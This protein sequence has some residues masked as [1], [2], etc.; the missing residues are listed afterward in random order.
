MKIQE[1]LTK[2]HNVVVTRGDVIRWVETLSNNRPAVALIGIPVV[3]IALEYAR[4]QY[5][6]VH[7]RLAHRNALA[8]LG[9]ARTTPS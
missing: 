7:S 4:T 9:R 1:I 5:Q 3:F 2:C 6:M 8:R